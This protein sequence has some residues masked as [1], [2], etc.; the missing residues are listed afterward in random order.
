MAAAPPDPLSSNMATLN[1]PLA[2][3]WVHRGANDVETIN[4]FL[5]LS[6]T[7]IMMRGDDEYA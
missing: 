4:D 6:I 3:D 1:P 2:L 7:V 5:G